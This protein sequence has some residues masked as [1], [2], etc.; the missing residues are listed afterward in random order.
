LR[1]V[2][3]LRIHHYEAFSSQ[4][5]KGNPAGVVLDGQH[6][7]DDEMQAIAKR[8]GFNETAFVLP[9]QSADLSARHSSSPFS[10]TVEDP[11]TG[12]A[13]GVMGAYMATHAASWMIERDYKLVVE[14]GRDVGRDGR[15]HVTVTNREPPFRVKI[16][17]TACYVGDLNL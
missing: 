12:T 9:S 7:S 5:G 14:Q 3:Q 15:V 8:V 10:G 2:V 4:P 1:K 16:A 17:G 6:L 11:I 13:S